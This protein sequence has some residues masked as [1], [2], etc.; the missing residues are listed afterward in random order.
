[1]GLKYTT[2]EFVG[3]G[4]TSVSIEHGLGEAPFLFAF[5]SDVTGEE[6]IGTTAGIIMNT[7]LATRYTTSVSKMHMEVGNTISTDGKNAVTNVNL[8]SGAYG[9]SSIDENVININRYGSNQNFISGKTYKWIA[10][11]DWRA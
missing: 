10:I 4:S 6:T 7:G 5:V 8:T 11:A 2:G 9:I 3:T 1:M